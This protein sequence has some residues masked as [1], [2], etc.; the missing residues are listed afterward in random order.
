MS[1]A[2]TAN[3]TSDRHHLD[4]KN[5]RIVLHQNR[6]A[7]KKLRKL[8]EWFVRHRSFRAE[9]MRRRLCELISSRHNDEIQPSLAKATD[10]IGEPG[11][12]NE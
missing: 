1:A 11:Q 7:L 10:T 3:R 9:N 8:S 6:S 12:A 2:D 4:G 5:P